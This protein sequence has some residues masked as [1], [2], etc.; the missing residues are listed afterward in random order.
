MAMYSHYQPKIYDDFNTPIKV[1]KDIE[2]YIPKDKVI[3][4]PFYN[5]GKHTLIDL[6]YNVIH[7]DKDFFEYEPEDYDII[8][9]NPPF[10]IKKKILKRLL[11]LDKPFILIMPI[12][13]LC[14]KYFKQYKDKIQ[15]IIP[16]KRY[17]FIP[18]LKSS[19]TFDTFFYCYKMNLEKDILW[20]E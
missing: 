5:D 9:D 3:W 4:C 6:Q 1:W 11:I 18:Q 13:T 19:A 14:S 20:L 8:V 7:E 12:S 10:S 17:N 15:I 16:P 2:K